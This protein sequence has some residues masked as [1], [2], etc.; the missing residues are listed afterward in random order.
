ME[1]VL[2][3]TVG[4]AGGR[5][6]NPTYH[7]L[8]DHAE[9]IRVEY[10]PARVGYEDLLRVFWEEHDPTARPWS[11]QYRSAIFTHGAEQERLARES[12]T[13]NEERLG[14][15]VYTKIETA[16]SFWPAEA[17]HQ[18]YLLRQAGF[19]MEEMRAAYPG[20]EE[21]AAS[22]AAARLNGYL[23]GYGGPERFE[24]EAERLGLGPEARAKLLALLVSHH[25]RG[26]ACAAPPPS[27][28]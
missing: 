14:R 11:A 1:G 26:A 16:G 18:K 5:K 19:L 28:R 2:R 27:P 6:E 3:T 10:D 4:Y 22:T 15:K 13:R 12:L 21:F 25:G 17:Y 24:G 7:S 8:G 23:G 20:E 9:T